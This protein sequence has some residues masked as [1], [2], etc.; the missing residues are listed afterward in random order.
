MGMNMD[1]I[2][3]K[4]DIWLVPS[5][6]DSAHLVEFYR[7]ACPEDMVRHSSIE[8]SIWKLHAWIFIVFIVSIGS[9]DALNVNIIKNFALLAR[10][11]LLDGIFLH[12]CVWCGATFQLFNFRFWG[13]FCHIIIYISPVTSSELEDD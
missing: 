10:S 11:G 1:V 5:S 6:I 8:L 7:I 2:I 4:V 9:F 12:R 13:F 3:I